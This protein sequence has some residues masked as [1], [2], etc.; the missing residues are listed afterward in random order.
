MEVTMKKVL[1]LLV[2]A[3]V[4]GLEAQA[5]IAEA[6]AV[7]EA[8]GPERA[9]GTVTDQL[10]YQAMDGDADAQL[11]L[12]RAYINYGLDSYGRDDY[13]EDDIVDS[14]SVVVDTLIY[15]QERRQRLELPTIED[16]LWNGLEWLASSSNLG[17]LYAL[18]DYACCLLEGWGTMVEARQAYRLFKQAA[19][20]GVPAAQYNLGLCYKYGLGV[21]EDPVEAYH[22]LLLA[23][24]NGVQQAYRVRDYY[25][26]YEESHPG[27]TK[28]LP[29]VTARAKKTLDSLPELP[30]DPDS[31]LLDL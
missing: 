29:E 11:R 31:L 30:H 16:D 19:E 5:V 27:D 6:C 15:N 28:L 18:N 9:G 8:V 3:V 13:A 23:S 10:F 25:G 20:A 12:G 1:V 7:A 17:N 4:I 26:Y 14:V 2:L 24:A 22:W 21:I